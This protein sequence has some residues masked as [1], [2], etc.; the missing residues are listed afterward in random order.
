MKKLILLFISISCYYSV[1]AQ[2][3]VRIIVTDIAAKAKDE[4]YIAGNFN[5]WNPAD[6]AAKMKPFAG[7]R[8]VIVL[9]DMDTGHYEFKF[10]RGS[11]DK[12][13]TTSKGEDI[14]NRVANING[15]TSLELTIAGWK[16]DAP[17]KPKP[18]TVSVNVYMIDTAFLYLN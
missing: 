6:Q 5:S 4:I 8:R 18:N 16:D 14:E 1:L 15:D 10:T 3:T 13:E 17:D 7:S 11:W 12:V 2:Y 9:K